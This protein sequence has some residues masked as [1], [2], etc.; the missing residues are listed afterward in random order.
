MNL[1]FCESKISYWAEQYLPNLCSNRLEAYNLE[2]KLTRV[3]DQV[4]VDGSLDLEL[5]IDVAK[6]VRRPSA[7]RVKKNKCESDVREITGRALK[8]Q[9]VHVQ[10]S[11]LTDKKVEKTL[12]GIGPSIASA[13]LH[14]FHKEP[15]PMNTKP[16]RWSLCVGE[17]KDYS[18]FEFWHEY[19][20]V[21][22]N[23]AH[24]NSVDMRTLDRALWEYE[25][26]KNR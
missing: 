19:V 5:L 3:V 23:L 25:R 13:I 12:Y 17:D 11:V 20:S 7:G 14:W 9:S 18:S 15:Y 21:C 24:R 6:W 1:R 2:M 16:A 26:Q 4:Q 10:W 22:R 8:S